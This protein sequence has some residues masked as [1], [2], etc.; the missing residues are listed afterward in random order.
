MGINDV[1]V[2]GLPDFVGWIIMAARL[3]P[4]SR[5]GTS[6]RRDGCREVGPSCTGSIPGDEEGSHYKWDL[7]G[8][9]R[10]YMLPCRR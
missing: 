8:R 4:A 3:G 2:D 5:K 10:L 1:H 9:D 7:L 6:G